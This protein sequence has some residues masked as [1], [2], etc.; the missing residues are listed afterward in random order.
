MH[1]KHVNTVIVITSPHNKILPKKDTLPADLTLLVLSAYGKAR[2]MFVDSTPTRSQPQE[3]PKANVLQ[4]APVWPE[5]M[6]LNHVLN[7]YIML[8]IYIYYIPCDT[9]LGTAEA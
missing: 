7:S 5:H 1:T 6:W 4:Q 3:V 2:E 9:P 8:Y